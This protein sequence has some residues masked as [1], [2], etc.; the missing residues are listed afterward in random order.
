[1][2]KGGSEGGSRWVSSDQTHGVLNDC[3]IGMMH[4][5]LQEDTSPM[6]VCMTVCCT[7]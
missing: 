2:S 6:K 4:D 1:V 3:L 5:R 7:T